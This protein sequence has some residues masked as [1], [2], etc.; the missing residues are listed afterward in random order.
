MA[1]LAFLIVNMWFATSMDQPA[2]MPILMMSTIVQGDDAITDASASVP[3]GLLVHGMLSVAFGM[4]FALIALCLRTNGSL[5]LAGSVY[6]IALYLVNFEIFAP[7]A[8]TVFEDANQPFEFAAHLL[9]GL[10]L[11]LAFFSS[12]TRRHDPVIAVTEPGKPVE[13]GARV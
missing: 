1:G 7:T 6:G 10:V 11:S 13:S 9:F 3:I 12:G 5:A 2:R 8:F 4:V